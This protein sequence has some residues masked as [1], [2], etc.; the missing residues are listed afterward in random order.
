MPIPFKGLLREHSAFYRFVVRRY[1]ALLKSLGIRDPVSGELRREY[2][3][4]DAKLSSYDTPEWQWL[5][6]Q[7]AGFELLSR[8]T[9]VPWVLALMPWQYQVQRNGEAPPE[10]LLKAYAQEEDLFY[11][12]PISVLEEGDASR[13]YIDMAHFSEKGH[14]LTGQVLS[15]ALQASDLLPSP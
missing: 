10:R 1:D 11:V 3:E 5:S 13:L 8:E 9:G 6:R 7:L 12:D 15:E 14:R 4:I 2:Q